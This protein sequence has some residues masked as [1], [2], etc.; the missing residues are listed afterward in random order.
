MQYKRDLI[1][2]LSKDYDIE[3]N[4]HIL[5]KTNH[6]ENVMRH[7]VKSSLPD[8]QRQAHFIRELKQLHRGHHPRRRRNTHH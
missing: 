4:S 8:P 1:V 5:G 7:F 6:H 3:P 2:R